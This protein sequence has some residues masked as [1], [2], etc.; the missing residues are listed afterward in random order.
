MFALYEGLVH[1][2]LCK[3]SE[4]NDYIK[5]IESSIDLF[6]K[7][8]KSCPQNFSNKLALLEAEYLALKNDSSDE[9][10]V[11]AYNKAINL[12]KQNNFI[13]ET[14][15]SCEKAGSYLLSSKSADP[16]DFFCRAFIFYKQ[17]GANVKMIE[18]EKL[19]PTYLSDMSS[20]NEDRPIETSDVEIISTVSELTSP[21]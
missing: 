16:K 19:Y 21:S 3:T 4:N 9:R 18:M 2:E 17:W 12:S 10:I 6:R 7:W 5:R 14:A 8:S 1:I 13:N 20:A 15:I 11:Q